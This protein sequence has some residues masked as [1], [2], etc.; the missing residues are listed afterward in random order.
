MVFLLMS[1]DE[2][3]MFHEWIGYRLDYFL[4]DG[5]RQNTPFDYTGI[6]GLAIGIPALVLLLLMWYRLRQFFFLTPATAGRLLIGSCFL[7]IGA[8]GFDFLAN[9][10]LRGPIVVHALEVLAEEG[11]E[12]I[13]VT[14]LCWGALDLLSVGNFR[15]EYDPLN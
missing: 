13:G 3:A 6:W 7:I 5:T 11:C 8:A 15:V 2:I 14:I 9:F 10:S 12:L 1:I 4:P